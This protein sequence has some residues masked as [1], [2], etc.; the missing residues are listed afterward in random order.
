MAAMLF[1]Q[2]KFHDPNLTVYKCRFGNHWHFGH[3]Q[4]RSWH[5]N[6]CK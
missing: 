2:K 3:V 5:P 1:F 6:R 4:G